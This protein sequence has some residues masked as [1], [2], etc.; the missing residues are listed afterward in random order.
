MTSTDYGAVSTIL[1]FAACDTRQCV[2]VSIVDDETL[3]LTE[4][5]IVTLD[6]TPALGNRIALK[7]V[8]GVIDIL[9]N[10]GCKYD[11]FDFSNLEISLRMVQLLYSIGL[12]IAKKTSNHHS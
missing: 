10:D 1:M 9:D 6:R 7:P 4:T 8:D 12:W 2:D 3:E 11:Y 5:F